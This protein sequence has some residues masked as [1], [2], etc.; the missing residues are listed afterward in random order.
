MVEKN[1]KIKGLR[2]KKRKLFAFGNFLLS[3]QNKY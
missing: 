3:S 1:T 2:I